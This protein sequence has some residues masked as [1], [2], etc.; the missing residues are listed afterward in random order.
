MGGRAKRGKE[1]MRQLMRSASEAR[2]QSQFAGSG[3]FPGCFGKYPDCPEAAKAFAESKGKEGFTE[4]KVPSDCAIC[5][6]FKW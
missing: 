2:E 1:N 4:D 5:P 6:F 3:K